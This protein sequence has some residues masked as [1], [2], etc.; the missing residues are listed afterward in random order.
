MLAQQKIVFHKNAA[1]VGTSLQ[2][3]IDETNPRK[4]TA[5]ARHTGQAPDIDGRVLLTAC[6][7]SPGELITVQINDYDGY[8]LIGKPIKSLPTVPISLSSRS[9]KS[10]AR[11]SLPVITASRAS[12]EAQGKRNTSRGR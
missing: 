12:V 4:K 1:L 10:V 3:L 2:V 9:A 11:L 5:L 8:D 6:T 7:A